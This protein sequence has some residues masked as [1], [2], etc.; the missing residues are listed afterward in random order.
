MDRPNINVQILPLEASDKASMSG[1]FVMINFG[2]ER[3]V[4]T[5]F[6]ENLTSSQYL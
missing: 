1:S 6:V 2:G 3:S 5:V 4:S